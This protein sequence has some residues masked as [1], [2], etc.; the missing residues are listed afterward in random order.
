MSASVRPASA[1]AAITASTASESGAA[2][3]PPSDLRHPDARDRGVILGTRAAQ[4]R[5]DPAG[6]VGRRDLVFGQLAVRLSARNEE[7][8]PHVFLLLEPRPHAHADARRFGLQIHEVRDQA[9]PR[10]RIDRHGRDGERRRVARI[11]LLMVDRDAD[12]D[13]GR[14]DVAHAEVGRSA[15][16]AHGARRMLERAAGVARG[17]AENAVAAGFPEGPTLL[18]DQRQGA[19]HAI[20]GELAGHRSSSLV[21][22]IKY[23]I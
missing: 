18:V 6:V 11:P 2:H 9:N 20:H 10:V 8:N 5:A 4:R 3:E 23:Q 13:A 22:R 17:K 14:R 12:D 7:R 1:T 19:L 16:A 21:A 15:V